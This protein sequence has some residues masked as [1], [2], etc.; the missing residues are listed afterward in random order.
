MVKRSD[1]HTTISKLHYINTFQMSSKHIKNDKQAALSDGKDNQKLM[2]TSS[3]M[4]IYS[5]KNVNYFSNIRH[6]LIDLIPSSMH[7][8]NVLEIGC[9]NGATLSYLKQIGIAQKT[10]GIELFPITPNKYDKIDMF[11]NENIETMI[12]PQYMLHSFDI[13]LVGDV[14]EHLVD[15]WSALQRISDL[16]KNDGKIIISLP[17]IRHYSVLNN[18]LFHGTFKYETSGILDQ[19]HLR[20]FCKKDILALIKNSGLKVETITSSFDKES[21]RSKKYWLNKITIG[22]LKDFFIFQ[23]L[24][25]AS[26]GNE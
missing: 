13:I 26:K 21:F 9:G 15:P 20:F 18:I 17:N 14:I 23:Y 24:I 12:F 8:C 3:N 25:V 7:Q 22:L 11:F 6:D 5:K 19:T 2:K 1:N 4:G 10:T 16:I